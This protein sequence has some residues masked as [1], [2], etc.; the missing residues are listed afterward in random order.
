MVETEILVGITG[1]IG[2][3]LAASIPY[4]LTKRNEIAINIQKTKLER[5]DDLLQKFVL[6][7]Q[8]KEELDKEKS[9]I[10]FVMAYQRA[11]SY[12]S[13]KVLTA[14]EEY[15]S[16]RR[17]PTETIEDFDAAYLR[18]VTEVAREKIDN[19]FIAIREDIQPAEP[20]FRFHSLTYS[21][22]LKP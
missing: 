19:I 13:P 20:D 10:E 15:I 16:F 12:A 17:A 14:I 2:A 9:A 22:K 3:V 18:K 4:Y 6:W 11:S 1:A 5:Y 8:S 21:E 7:L